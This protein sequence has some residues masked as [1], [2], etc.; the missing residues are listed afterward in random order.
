MLRYTI[1]KEFLTAAKHFFVE[2]VWLP[3][4]NPTYLNDMET[5][6]RCDGIYENDWRLNDGSMAVKCILR[7]PN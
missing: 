4:S 2:L 1:A 5:R 3:V 6:G 7:G